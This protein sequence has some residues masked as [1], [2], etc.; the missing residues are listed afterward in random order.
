MIDIH[1]HLIYGVDDGA[2]DLASSLAMA[3]EAVADGITRIVCTSHSSDAFPWQQQLIDERFAELRERLKDTIEL[4]LGCE[5]HTTYENIEDATSHPLRYSFDGK[6]YL[7]IEFPNI[8]VPPQIDDSI[9]EL[10]A[11]G[12][13]IIIAHPE[14]Y[15]FL[16]QETER[17]ANWMRK[18]CLVQVTAGSLYGRFGRAAEAFSNELLERNWIHFLATDGHHIKWRPPHL[19]KAFEYVKDRQG[20]E[21]ARRLCLLNP[22]AAVDGA[23]LPP[24][25]DAIGLLEGKPLRFKP[26]KQRTAQSGNHADDGSP[27]GKSFF[28]RLFGR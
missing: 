19:R 28:S 8:S 12:Y 9:F 27:K 17:L 13:T 24:Q 23:E 18:G 7:L 21:A 6:G 20:E 22:Q 3:R 16:Q 10:Q 15:P 25:P 14:R 5:L 1:Q 11:A 26:S 4:S 2:P